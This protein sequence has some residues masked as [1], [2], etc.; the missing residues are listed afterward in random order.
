MEGYTSKANHLRYEMIQK[1]V[2]LKDKTLQNAEMKLMLPDIDKQM[3]GIYRELL[4]LQS[5]EK[6][7]AEFIKRVAAEPSVN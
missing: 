6:Q 1:Y 3:T 5:K 7:A 4:V 2:A